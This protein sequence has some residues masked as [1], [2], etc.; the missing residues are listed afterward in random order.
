M[1]RPARPSPTEPGRG[2]LT[3]FSEPISQPRTGFASEF[4]VSD[5]THPRITNSAQPASS[6]QAD[7]D[8]DLLLEY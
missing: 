8:N 4:Q 1:T 3:I 7:T 6:L 2:G 5:N